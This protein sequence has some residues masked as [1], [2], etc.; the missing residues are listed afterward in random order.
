[1]VAL[2]VG[3]K[4]QEMKSK[5]NILT[6]AAL[7]WTLFFWVGCKSPNEKVEDAKENVEEA[8]KKLA[9]AREDSIQAAEE[10]RVFKVETQEKIAANNA[11]ISQLKASKKYLGK[12]TNEEY[13]KKIADLEARNADLQTRM[14]D[15]E[16]YHSDWETFK[17]EFNHD[18][19]ELGKAMKDITV[20]NEK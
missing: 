4:T 11:Q 3:S 18:M 7:A 9:E 20:D 10:W 2:F 1:M 16:K 12:P 6:L 17:R 5:F 19:D 15:Y 8:E 13:A 14:N